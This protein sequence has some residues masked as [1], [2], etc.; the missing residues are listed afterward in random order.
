VRSRNSFLKLYLIIGSCIALVILSWLILT[1]SLSKT[2]VLGLY[3]IA[4]FVAICVLF[5]WLII[6]TFG[7]FFVKK[8]FVIL[9]INKVIISKWVYYASIIISILFLLILLNSFFQFFHVSTVLLARILPILIFIFLFSLETTIFHNLYLGRKVLNLIPIPLIS[10]ENK[11]NL[12][13]LIV[14]IGFSIAVGYHYFQGAYLLKP[15][16]QNTFL[17]RPDDRFNDFYNPVRGSADLD[18]FRPDKI[19]Y[20]GGYPPFGYLVAYLFS[21][22]K[23]WTISL[24]LFIITFFISFLYLM[25]YFL[26]RQKKRI[27]LRDYISLFVLT[28]L[29]YPILFAIDR[30]NFDLIICIML[31]LFV[32]FYQKKKILLSTVFLGI[33]IAIKPFAG[34]FILLYLFDKEYKAALILL[35]NVLVLTVISL[36]LFK[37]GLFIESQKFLLD[38]SSAGKLIVSGSIAHFSSDLYNFLIILIS[39]ILR[40]F[41]SEVSL[42]SN[43]IFKLSYTIFALSVTIGFSIYCWK[44]SQPFWKKLL[45]LTCL[46]ILLPFASG[47]YRLTYLFPPLFLFL[48]SKE[49][50]THD[51]LLI[52]LFG[53]LLI[54]KNYYTLNID[55]NIGMLLNPIIIVLILT[56]GIKNRVIQDNTTFEKK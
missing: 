29:T 46:I 14:M 3:S 43:S 15:Y 40:L 42:I 13:V 34:L 2:S 53:L 31:F 35:F 52:I 30:A 55:Q 20:K 38:F 5:L 25:R 26:F 24:L 10:Y 50:G 44:N 9:L 45:I 48:S 39:G 11:V 4:R 28:F 16:P 17:F 22:V 37:D 56:T 47:D 49:K 41:N 7:S 36:S 23:P 27:D 32:L 6:L 54:P 33:A 21:L 12:L 51:F 8:D 1:P 19:S 18:P